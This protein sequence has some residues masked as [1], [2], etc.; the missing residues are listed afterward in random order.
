[1]ATKKIKKE[2][3]IEPFFKDMVEVWFLFCREKFQESPTF[4]GS[5]PRDLKSIIKTLR[6]RAVH[7]NIE[8]TSD[9]AKLRFKNFLDFAWEDYWLKNNWLLFNINRQKDKIFFNIKSSLNKNQYH[10]E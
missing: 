5:A 10:Y 2:K 4:D 8:W 3:V 6:E 7:S 9:I 1:M